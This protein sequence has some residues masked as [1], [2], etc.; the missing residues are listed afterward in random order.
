MR[1]HTIQPTAHTSMKL[2][3]TGQTS[4]TYA[5]FGVKIERH[6]GQ[7]GTESQ[8]LLPIQFAIL[9]AI[10]TKRGCCGNTLL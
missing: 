8:L 1:F 10:N 9:I 5:T 7:L 2:T 4:Q 3:N 6:E